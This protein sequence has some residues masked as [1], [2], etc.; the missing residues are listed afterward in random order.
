M[1]SLH[2]IL[3]HSHTATAS[4]LLG[5]CCTSFDP[6]LAGTFGPLSSRSHTPAPTLDCSSIEFRTPS[7]ALHCHIV[8]L[9]GPTSTS[10]DLSLPSLPFI[11]QIWKT[12]S[13][14]YPCP[15]LQE[16]TSITSPTTVALLSLEIDLLI[17]HS[18]CLPNA[19]QASSYNLLVENQQPKLDSNQWLR[20]FWLDPRLILEVSLAV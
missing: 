8:T 12:S 14:N 11:L 1:H 2:T 16:I 6:L 18:M 9:C 17:S 3:R 20:S 10:L 13:G 4:F 5:L 7:K 15:L 19:H